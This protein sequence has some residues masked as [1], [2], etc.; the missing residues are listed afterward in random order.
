VRGR[1][2]V[3]HLDR[4]EKARS[5]IMEGH[6]G[7]VRVLRYR[8]MAPLFL[9]HGFHSHEYTTRV[10]REPDRFRGEVKWARRIPAAVLRWLRPL[11]PSQIFIL[12]PIGKPPR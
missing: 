4:R 2:P 3:V 5:P 9:E 11:F 8:R 7:N 1:G 12:V 6:V 10:L